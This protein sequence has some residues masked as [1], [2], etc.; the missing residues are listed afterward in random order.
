MKK[1]IFLLI[2][3]TSAACQNQPKEIDYMTFKERDFNHLDFLLSLKQDVFAKNWK[4]FSE[5]HL[6]SPIIYYTKVGTYVFNP[7]EHIRSITKYKEIG[8]YKSE[9]PVILLSKKHLDTLNFQF[10]SSYSNDSNSLYFN[11]NILSFQSFELTQKFIPEIM[12]I[13]DWSIMVIHEL[14]HS[15]QRSIQEH[16]TYYKNLEIPG[17]PDEF[18]GNYYKN[19]DWYKESVKQENNILKSIWIENKDVYPNLL[20]YDSIK[21]RRIDRIKMM[22][23]VDIREIEDYEIMVEG[24]ARYIE[25]LCKMYL[26]K[27]RPKTNM[28]IRNDTALITNLF[29]K[30][31]IVNDK[32]LFNINNDR[33]YYPLGFN[34]SMILEQHFPNYKETLY[35]EKQNFND[36]LINIILKNSN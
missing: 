4:A 1:I 26:S 9:I 13:Q 28:L 34:I 25:A 36:Y 5:K 7:N 21:T 19:I 10:H 18:L 33:Y 14:F 6:F 16:E 30:K 12:D 8:L 2:L 29:N 11:E 3:I 17:G 32:G 27:N 24:Q 31:E 35:K 23:G 15:Y 22:F 20:A